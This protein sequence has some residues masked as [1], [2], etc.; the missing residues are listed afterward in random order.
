MFS[1]DKASEKSPLLS[2]PQQKIV[3]TKFYQTI[4]FKII[5]IYLVYLIIYCA[6]F[7]YVKIVFDD[8][9]KQNDVFS[10]ILTEKLKMTNEALLFNQ[11]LADQATSALN[12]RSSN[13]VGAIYTS[14]HLEAKKSF[15]FDDF[16]DN[17]TTSDI[18]LKIDE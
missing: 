4:Y 9:L 10:S 11:Y 13:L 16:I 8:F 17:L 7:V 1:E 2:Q 5:L 3:K 15:V 18:C 6:K 12:I 14:Y